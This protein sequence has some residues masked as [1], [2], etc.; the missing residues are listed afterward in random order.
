M[1]GFYLLTNNS[2]VVHAQPLAALKPPQPLLWPD[3]KVAFVFSLK[4]E[5][6]VS[7]AVVLWICGHKIPHY[8]QYW[9]QRSLANFKNSPKLVVAKV[10][11]H[12]NYWTPKLIIWRPRYISRILNIVLGIYNF[13]C[14]S[15][16]LFSLNCVHNFVKRCM[17]K[18]IRSRKWPRKMGVVTSGYTIYAKINQRNR[19]LGQKYV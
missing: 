16:S 5:F 3:Q 1:G 11:C 2:N 4:S 15:E 12:Q 7:H 13:I 6:L 10:C 8:T 9:R 19:F 18:I 17:S 14:I